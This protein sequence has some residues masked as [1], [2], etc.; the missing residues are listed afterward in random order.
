MVRT[1]LKRQGWRRSIVS[2]LLMLILLFGPAGTLDY[3]QAWLFAVVFVASSIAIGLYFS[4]YDPRL[5]ER[6]MK[7]GPGAETEPSQ[8]IIIFLIISG[9]SLLLAFPSFDHRSHWSNVPVWLVIAANGGVVLSF[10]IF[11][12]VLK[13]NSYAASTVTVEAGQPVVSTGVYGIVR[14]P[15]YAGALLLLFCMPLAL[16]SFWGLL[17]ALASVPLLMWRLLDEERVLR[18]DLAGYTEY[19]QTVRYRLIPYIW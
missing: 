3:R 18:R 17:V 8:K 11:F 4:R 15:M 13:Q 6:R 5:L 10:V 9:F 12:V 16:G 2:L 19:C 1:E 7:A 14:H